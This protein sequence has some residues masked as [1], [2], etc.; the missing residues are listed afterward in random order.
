[1]KRALTRSQAGELLRAASLLPLASRDA[2]ISEVDSRLCSVRRQL[3]DA[4]VSA[5]I[6]STLTVLDVTT[7]H[8]MCDTQPKEPPMA[9][10]PYVHENLPADDD[11]VLPDGGT[12]RVPMMLRDSATDSSSLHRPGPRFSTD[13]A[14][15]A[16]VE[17]VYQD[18][19]RKLMDAWKNPPTAVGRGQQPGDQCTINGAPGH[20]NSKLEC[21][22]D[23]RQ[24][25]VPRTMDAAT[26][27]R[28]KDAA[29]LESVRD[30]EQA[31]KR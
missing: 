16:H 8:F 23:Q 31:W 20:L 12:V 14:A 19:K 10:S 15:R 4:D 2:F 18:E 5:A 1:M 9:K 24:D 11:E 26:A 7:S 25:A 6:V 3:T 28:I 30:L 17:E 21:V 29:W 22:P 27:Q 13:A